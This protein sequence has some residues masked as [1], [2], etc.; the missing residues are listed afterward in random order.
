MVVGWS[1]KDWA[2]DRNV[3]II[4][5]GPS[6]EHHIDDITKYTKESNSILFKY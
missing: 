2:K 5:S 4:G 3:L 6:I 1:A